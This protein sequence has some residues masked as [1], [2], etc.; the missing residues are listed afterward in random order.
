LDFVDKNIYYCEKAYRQRKK[1]LSKRYWPF[2][3]HMLIYWYHKEELYGKEN[4]S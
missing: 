4:E 3:N 1:I 2:I